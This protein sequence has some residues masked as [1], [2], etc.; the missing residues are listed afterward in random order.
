[1]IVS[2]LSNYLLYL[3]R[4]LSLFL[5]S[6]SV[7]QRQPPNP[8]HRPGQAS[9]RHFP[10][11][12]S[13]SSPSSFLPPPSRIHTIYNPRGWG[14]SDVR[15]VHRHIVFARSVK[16]AN[17]QQRETNQIATSQSQNPPHAPRMSSVHRRLRRAHKTATT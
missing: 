6:V 14:I 5:E 8:N 17:A 3:L 2:C 4:L 15:L 9:S 7:I 12:S 16:V 11:L 13:S 10:L 1:M